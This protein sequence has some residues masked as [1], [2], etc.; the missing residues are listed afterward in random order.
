MQHR[1]SILTPDLVSLDFDLAGLGSR[2][3]ALI[4][5]FILIGVAGFFILVSALMIGVSLDVRGIDFAAS[6]GLAA[7]IFLGFVLL[8]GY[9]VF[10]EA[11]YGGRTPG[12][13]WAGIRVVREDGLPIGWRESA[14]RNLVRAAD[15]FP[16]PACIVGGLAVMFSGKEQRLGDMVAGTLV[17]REDFGHQVA[18]RTSEW[19]AAWVA[20]AETGRSQ[21]AIVLADTRIEASRI[22]IIERYLTRRH[23]LPMARRREIAIR[24]AGPFLEALDPEASEKTADLETSER[25]LTEIL[26]RAQGESGAMAEV[27]SQEAA[28][29]KRRQWTDLDRQITDLQRTGRGGLRRLTADQLTALIG[30]YRALG[31]DLARSRSLGR[32]S[33]LA[34]R[35][36][37]VAVRAHNVL[38]GHLKPSRAGSGHD[39]I[40]A[41]PRTVR[42]HLAGVAVSAFLLFGPAAISYVAVQ[43]H[44]DLGY[45]L[46]PEGFRDFEPA[47]EDS[48]HNIPGVARPIAAS[49]IM[50]NNVQ[51][52][53]LA[54]GL[55]LTA[56]LGTA[57]ILIFN[58]VSLGA[59][60]GW[61]T[62]TGNSRA[63]WGWIMPHGGTELLAI[64]LAGAAGLLLG[65]AIIA[66]GQVRRGEA[67]RRVAMKALTIELGVM[68]MLVVA[69]LI[70]GFVSPSSIGYGERI[71]VLVLTLVFWL[72]YLGLG[73]L[74]FGSPNID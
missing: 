33:V 69:G 47:R 63:L 13:R 68:G 46:V 9:F 71:G 38:Y 43:L 37:M 66:P 17:V 24:L 45:D 34:E 52:T 61:M 51:V 72:A 29:R 3:L 49:G 22:Q 67:L 10:F 26:A 14:L 23:S 15:I 59:V 57:F 1:V 32:H 8:W 25:V 16:P 48:L 36:N 53:L 18:G 19:E 2:L 70:E 12:K 65:G 55:G 28:S 54:F 11:L 56:G 74:R 64:V 39:W 41:F 5:D 7:A 4:V 20:R 30:A 58:G 50:T 21:R 73:G 42:R 40:F 62:A 44:P 27:T 60:A 6:W 31:C 35:L